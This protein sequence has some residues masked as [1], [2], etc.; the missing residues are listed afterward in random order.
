MSEP[1]LLILGYGPNNGLAIAQRFTAA[2]YRIAVAPRSLEDG[3]FNEEGWLQLRVD[4]SHPEALP[5]LFT[6][7][8]EKMGIPSVVVYNGE[9]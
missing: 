8:K 7:V 9:S 5:G 1:V 2:G 3:K 6:T 4:L